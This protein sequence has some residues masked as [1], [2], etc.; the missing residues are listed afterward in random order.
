[1]LIYEEMLPVRQ[2]SRNHFHLMQCMSAA[3]LVE[4]QEEGLQL[5]LFIVDI[6]FYKSKVHNYVQNLLSLTS[7]S[8]CVNLNYPLQLPT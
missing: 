5:I 3:T 8:Y 7:L 2:K 6:E 4:S 1:M